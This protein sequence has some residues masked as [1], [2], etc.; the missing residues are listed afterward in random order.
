MSYKLHNT[1][2]FIHQTK[3]QQKQLLQRDKEPVLLD[4]TY[5]I[6]KYALPLFLMVV[7]T[8]F[9]NIPGAKFVG[10]SETTAHTAEALF[11]IKNWNPQVL[12]NNY[13]GLRSSWFPQSLKSMSAA[14]TWNKHGFDGVGKMG[15]SL[16]PISLLHTTAL[17][18]NI[19]I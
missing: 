12:P 19:N 8:N 17:S 1:S 18:F 3:Q 2:L 9:R 10:E 13:K 11:I 4:A 6:T 15:S 7:R 14:S 5:R 16:L